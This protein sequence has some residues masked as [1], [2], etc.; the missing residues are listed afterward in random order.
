MSRVGIEPTTL[1]LWVLCSTNW[2]TPTWCL[3]IN[4]KTC[5]FQPHKRNT[6]SLVTLAYFCVLRYSIAIHRGIEEWY[7]DKSGLITMNFSTYVL[8]SVDHDKYYI[9]STNNIYRRLLEHNGEKAKWTKTYQPWINVF[10]KKFSTRSEAV[11][12]EKYLKSLKNKSKLRQYI[13][14]IAG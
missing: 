9:G 7:P 4:L 12:F 5:F 11:I 1:G 3:Y 2:A 14:N 6:F 10:E 13:S 8:Y